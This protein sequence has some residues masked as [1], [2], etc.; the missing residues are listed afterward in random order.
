MKRWKTILLR[1]FGL[2]LLVV[3][4]LFA[5]AYWSM[6]PTTGPQI[7]SYSSPRVSLLI[8]DIQEDYTGPQA[9]K[10]FRDGNRIVTASNALLGQA[11][12]KGIIVVYIKNVIDNPVMS[13]LTG[14][15]NAPGFP[16]TELDRR[17]MKIPGSKTFSKNRSDAFSNSELDAYLR[18]NQVDKL[19]LT[20]LDAAY[21]VNATV[22]GALNRGYNVT[23]YSEGIATESGQSLEK[24]A[25]N[26]REAGAQVRTGTE[27]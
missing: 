17:L 8:V 22:R 24:L 11:Q 14:G 25:Q 26:W 1:I 18:E 10:R 13:V 6:R 19:L 5:M 16:G 27:M 12:A 15:I 9:K 3:M 20:G 4:A 2:V 23:I 7:G 21:C